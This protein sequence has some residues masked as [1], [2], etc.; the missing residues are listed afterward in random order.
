MTKIF[1]GIQPTGTLTV[2]NYLGAI[3][4]W[5]KMQSQNDCLFCLVDLHA[6]T[7]P[8]SPESLRSACLNN[9]AIYIACGL[10]VKKSII[11][12]QSAVPQHSELGWILG[13]STPLGWLNRMTQF[14][15]K[16]GKHREQAG[17]GLYAYPVLMAA[18]ILLYH[19]THVPVGDDQ[20]QHLE[21]TRDIAGA[22]NRQFK[23]EYFKEPAMINNPLA[24]RIMSLRDGTKKMSKSDESDFSRINLT[25]EPELIAQKIKKAKTDAIEGV[26]YDPQNR[27]EISNLINIYCAFTENSHEIANKE[28][29]NYTNA[30]FKEEL[31]NII[32]EYLK[33]I[34]Q[35]AS[36][37]LKDHGTLVN[38]MNSGAE[39]ATE[40][41]AK[42]ISEVKKIVGFC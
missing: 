5:L 22:F 30:Q 17:L 40:I 1:S 36:I 37:L 6:I 13:C 32:I 18:D 26:Y 35:E 7:I 10:D 21:I 14:K 33:P 19:A 15:D 11:F 31:T 3:K 8:Q 34:Q 41:A 42:T 28:F 24:T 27:P 2:G 25:D 38:L 39:R 4:N 29:A 20:T 23:V 16:A 12:M 9:F